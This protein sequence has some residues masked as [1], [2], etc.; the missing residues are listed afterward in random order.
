MTCSTCT[1]ISEPEPC[2]PSYCCMAVADPLQFDLGR[3]NSFTVQAQQDELPSDAQLHMLHSPQANTAEGSLNTQRELH[4]IDLPP[5]EGLLNINDLNQVQS[6]TAFLHACLLDS[7]QMFVCMGTAASPCFVC[8][9]ESLLRGFSCICI[10]T[11]LCIVER[12]PCGT[13]KSTDDILSAFSW[14]HLL[15][16][17]CKHIPCCHSAIAASDGANHGWLL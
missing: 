14:A 17:Y 7:S 6:L 13:H 8:T 16:R 1:F 9:M 3:H 2:I 10:C 12:C 4:R 15:S 5:N 11:K